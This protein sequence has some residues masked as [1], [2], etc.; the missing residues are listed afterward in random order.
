MSRSICGGR[1][2]PSRREHRNRDSTRETVLVRW[3]PDDEL[4]VAVI[5]QQHRR[6][7]EMVNGLAMAVAAGED[8]AQVQA[9]LEDLARFTAHHF[10]TEEDL[11]ERYQTASART[12]RE[13]H[14]KLKDEL[15]AIERQIDSSELSRTLSVINA[16]LLAHIRG[17]DRELTREL[18]SQGVR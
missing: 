16:W 7:A 4:G 9:M 3:S 8:T 15:A 11:M 18:R 14:R 17:A 12:H 13:Q 2:L 5:D 1:D 10:E 6:L